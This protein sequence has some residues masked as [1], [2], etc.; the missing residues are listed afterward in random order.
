MMITRA[1][2]DDNDELMIKK[3]LC[4]RELASAWGV[5]PRKTNHQLL[6][7]EKTE[8]RDNKLTMVAKLSASQAMRVAWWWES[9][10]LASNDKEFAMSLNESWWHNQFGGA[11]TNGGGEIRG[12][13]LFYF[14]N[15][16]LKNYPFNLET[17]SFCF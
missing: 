5:K 14:I 12:L 4:W 3:S 6:K 9:W 8:S 16:T 2:D 11:I 13:F 17:F 1:H 7:F 10:F 15:F